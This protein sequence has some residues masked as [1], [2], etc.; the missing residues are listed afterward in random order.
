MY[1]KD[2]P[3]ANF[4]VVGEGERVIVDFARFLQGKK[5][6]ADITMAFQRFYLRPNYLLGQIY[7][8]MSMGDFSLLFYGLRFLFMLKG[9]LN[10]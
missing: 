9:G 1:L 10:A 8:R 4:C 7:K 6:I 3:Y 5:N 2:V